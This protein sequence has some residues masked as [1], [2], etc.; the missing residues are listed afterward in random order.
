MQWVLRPIMCALTWAFVPTTSVEARLE[1][2]RDAWEAKTGLVPEIIPEVAAPV[3]GGTCGW[4]FN[5]VD[6]PTLG[7]I[8]EVDIIWC[9]AEHGVTT[10]AAV[11]RGLGLGA[12]GLMVI[13]MVMRW[14]SMGSSHETG[15]DEGFQGSM[16]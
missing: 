14:V 8:P 10:Q 2:V 16:T 11:M 6:T 12:L 5:S 1:N 7:V 15:P 3:V 9:P 13:S 4:G